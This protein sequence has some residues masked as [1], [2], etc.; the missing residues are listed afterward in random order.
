[1]SCCGKCAFCE[2][3]VKKAGE[4]IVSCGAGRA[5][6]GGPGRQG[7]SGRAGWAELEGLGNDRGS[8]GHD[9]ILSQK[10]NFRGKKKCIVP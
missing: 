1:M 3:Q 10:A 4:K 2:K 5:G 6:R 8:L 7:L 9:C